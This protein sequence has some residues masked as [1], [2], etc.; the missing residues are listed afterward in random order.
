MNLLCL[1]RGR[2][3]LSGYL[4]AGSIL[5]MSYCTK[6][7][8]PERARASALGQTALPPA[9]QVRTASA[10]R[11]RGPGVPEFIPNNA[12]FWKIAES[13]SVQLLPAP[14]PPRQDRPAPLTQASGAGVAPSEPCSPPVRS[15]VLSSCTGR[16]AEG[17]DRRKSSPARSP[18]GNVTNARAGAVRAQRE[19]GPARDPAAR[20]AGL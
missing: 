19:S 16:A 20:H 7:E 15:R 4:G 10:A 11:S 8:R 9:R 2:P 5:P 18:H 12:M 3:R 17:R 6:M 14:P 13:E 1:L